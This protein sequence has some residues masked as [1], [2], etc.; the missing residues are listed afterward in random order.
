MTAAWSHGV[1]TC[2]VLTLVPFFCLCF[3]LVRAWVG[4][5]ILC[6]CSR[7]CISV[8]GLVWFPIRGSCLFRCLW[9]RTILRQPVFPLWFVGSYFLF[10]VFVAPC[11]TVNL[12]FLFEYS[13]LLKVLWIRT[14]LH[15][16]PLLLLPTTIVTEVVEVFSTL[17][18]LWEAFRFSLTQY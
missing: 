4:G 3:S 1:Y 9:L 18:A 8:F 2:H 15:F 5:G 17:L 6:F 10:S 12:L 11:R 13:S 7:F 14:M 16:G